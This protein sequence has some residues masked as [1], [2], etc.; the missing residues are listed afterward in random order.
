MVAMLPSGFTA[1]LG[2]IGLG[3]SSAAVATLAPQ[4]D[5][6]AQPLLL[7]SAAVL[8]VANL[9]C[10]LLAVACAT[11]GGTLLY[12]G[13]YVVTRAD[14][15]A[16]PALF[17]PGLTLF[18]AT[19]AASYTQR[20]RSA[21]HPLVTPRRGRTLL[22]GTV[23]LGGALLIISA[24]SGSGTAHTVAPA[25]HETAPGQSMPGPSMHSMQP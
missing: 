21:C 16:T 14:G 6:V 19:Y 22:A 5:A 7:F 12:L 10:S 25:H 17:Y 18:L 20:R 24:A 2:F 9:R 1:A 23:A 11:L 4:L 15:T 3:S 8:A 13:M